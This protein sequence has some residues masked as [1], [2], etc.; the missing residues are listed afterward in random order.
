MTDA[1]RAGVVGVGHL[2]ALHA[3]KYRAT[4]GA[5]LVGVYDPDHARAAEVASRHSCTAFATLAELLGEVDCASIAAST[6]AHHA[7]ASEAIARGVHVLVEKPLAASLADATSI[8]EAASA[9][10]VLL[11]VGHLERFNPAFAD[12]P[13]IVGHPRFIECHRLAP[14]AGRGADI[15]VV[16]DVMIHDLDLISFVVGRP[17][18]SVEAIG[19]PV[20]SNHADI[21][22]ARLR[23]EG[24]CIANVT[25][26]RVSLKR[27]RRLR[28]FQEDAYVAVDFDARSL[29]IVR[30]RAGAGPI[31]LNSP[32]ESIEVE[33]RT[34]AEDADPLRDEI[35]ALHGLARDNVLITHGGDE[36]LR[37]AVTTF[38]DPGSTFAMAEPS[39]SL[40]PVL[41]GIQDAKLFRLPLDHAWQLPA[42]AAQQLNDAGAR[43]TCLVNP[44]APSG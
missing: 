20:L 37:L 15:D 24:G 33:E 42:D 32:M 39:Y 11:Q 26:S 31:D 14:F 6:A 2:G 12:L 9:A 28:I 34:F 1:V 21:A 19:V 10:G 29:R 35:A 27:E 41:A 40:Y 13:S 3:A 17:L 43:L 18:L 22:N 44:H 8:V 4:G 23:F 25:A 16:F 30:R 38:V 36:G 5:R 7:A